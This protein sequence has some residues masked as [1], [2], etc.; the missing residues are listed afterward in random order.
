MKELIAHLRFMQ[1]FAHA[2]HNLVRGKS[3]FEDHEFFGAAYSQHEADFDAVVERLI[4]SFGQEHVDFVDMSKQAVEL[5]A[6]AL[7]QN[8]ANNEP[9][10]TVQL[11]NESR[12]CDM[13]N[14]LCRLDGASEG[15]KQLLGGMA[16][17]SESRQYKLKQ[18]L[19]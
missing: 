4:G 6:K 8:S 15:L 10:F 16:D 12:M 19:K 7:P 1:L 11:A 5:L 3:F 13:I 18:R 17:L 14:Q 9:Y 2:A